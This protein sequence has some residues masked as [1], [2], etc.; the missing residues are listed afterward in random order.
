M[1]EAVKKYETY[2]AHNKYLEGKSAS[3]QPGH[4][5]AAAQILGYKACFHITTAFSTSVED[6][7]DPVLS[8]QESSFQEDDD[9]CE[10]E[11]A[12]GRKDFTSLISL[13]RL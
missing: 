10:V 13:K 8:E 11:S 7:L 3:S 2:V 4:Q 1:Y 9:Q 6:S 12:K 5:R